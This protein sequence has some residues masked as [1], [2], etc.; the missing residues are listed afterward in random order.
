MATSRTIRRANFA[1]PYSERHEFYSPRTVRL[2]VGLSVLV[3]VGLLALPFYLRHLRGETMEQRNR[4]MLIVAAARD[5][6]ELAAPALRQLALVDSLKEALVGRLALYDE[7]E[8]SEYR[9]DALLVHLADLLPDG[10]TLR[11]VGVQPP[12]NAGMGR[13][14]RGAQANEV[15]E[16]LRDTLRMQVNG[17][18]RSSVEL[19][20]F[21]Q[22]LYD[23]P[24]FDAVVQT[25]Q[26]QEQGLTFTITARLPGSDQRLGGEVGPP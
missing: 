2:L 1:Y 7:V 16:E 10:V 4:L 22:A 14:V 13:A 12:L 26:V 6:A 15:P 23:S 25:E 9:M 21:R 20:R 19:D 18:A 11:T 3:V 17:A 5:Q 24:L 8:Q